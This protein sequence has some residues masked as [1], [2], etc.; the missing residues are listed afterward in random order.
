M[1]ILKYFIQIVLIISMVYMIN[2]RPNKLHKH[3]ANTDEELQIN[4]EILKELQML[5]M[6]E[7]RI[8]KPFA[9]FR[10]NFIHRP[11]YGRYQAA[12]PLEQYYL[13][14]PYNYD[15]RVGISPYPVFGGNGVY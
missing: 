3:K 4:E 5:R 6:R 15:G 2:G 14:S 10:R 12:P 11:T 7:N 8:Q 9:Q 1:H 13:P